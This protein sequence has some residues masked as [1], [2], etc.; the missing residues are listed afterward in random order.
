MKM[1][2]ANHDAQ[3]GFPVTYSTLSPEALRERVLARYPLIPPVS[4]EYLYRGL[5]DNYLVRDSRS[6]YVFRAYRHNWRDIRDIEAELE[7]VEFLKSGGVGVSFPIADK[8]GKT[9]Q[10]IDAPEGMRHAVLFSHADGSS[11]LPRMTVRQARITGRE[12]SLMHRLTEKKR[13]GNSRCYLDITSLLFSSFH[14][15]RPFLEE[16]DEDISMLDKIVTKLA[17]KFERVSLHE[18]SFGICHG[19][20]HPSNYHIA[21]GPRVT[22]FDFDACCCSW[23]VLDVAAF[24]YA[25]TQIYRNAA[26]LNEEF[27][28]GYREARALNRA[29]LSL[30]PYFGA[31]HRIWVLATQCS[32]FEVFSHFV[33]TNMKRNI[34]RNLRSYVNR[35]CG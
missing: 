27:I 8:S 26:K 33:R 7:L 30:I 13:L 15:I 5:N 17:V 14:A 4:C 19:D 16:S 9:I 22:L 31:V 10:Q 2:H 20:L 28:N 3:A 23:F 1:P 24:C 18:L 29:E 11:P 25:T 34:I 32:N 21:S 12:I 35:Y 6:K